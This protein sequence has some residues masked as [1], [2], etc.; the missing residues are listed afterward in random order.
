MGARYMD[1]MLQ[2]AYDMALV[3][4]K[5]GSSGLF[6]KD[7]G[8]YRGSTPA[9]AFW[10]GFNGTRSMLAG[11]GTLTGAQY[12]AGKTFRKFVAGKSEYYSLTGETQ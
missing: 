3:A 2:N 12:Q 4:A 9:C 7:G 8:Q 1:L 11:R 5:N 6:T 10:D